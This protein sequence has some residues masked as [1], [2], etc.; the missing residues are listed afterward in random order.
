MHAERDRS[1]D[2][3]SSFE[4]GE[5]L[6][7]RVVESRPASIAGPNAVPPSP[8]CARV[9]A[10]P[11]AE[12]DTVDLLR[13]EVASLHDAVDA[14]RA[15]VESL[16][17][18]LAVGKAVVRVSEDQVAQITDNMLEAMST[19]GFEGPVKVDGKPV[20]FKLRARRSPG[21]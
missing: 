20:V 5:P 17:R 9:R 21:S 19:L 10:D 4:A 12:P 18:G 16:I 13:A 8:S 15:K 2:E 1:D 6:W 3:R 11:A 7:D 14:L